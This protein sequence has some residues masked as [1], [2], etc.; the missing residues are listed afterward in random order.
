[1]LRRLLGLAPASGSIW[2]GGACFCTDAE[3]VPWPGH[4]ATK[5][6]K[7]GHEVVDAKVQL[8][9]DDADQCWRVI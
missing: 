7:Y 4:Y 8:T 9:F 6:N 3:M 5:Q 2:T 1:M